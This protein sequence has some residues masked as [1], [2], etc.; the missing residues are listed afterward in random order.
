MRDGSLDPRRMRL[1]LFLLTAVVGLTLAFI[2]FWGY[3]YAVEVAV[4]VALFGG[5]VV[6]LCWAMLS[7]D[8]NRVP[9]SVSE[10]T[11]HAAAL[12]NSM[13]AVPTIGI[14]TALPHETAAVLTVLGDP[15]R[16]H[17]PGT[18]AGRTYWRAE[19]KSANDGQHQVIVAQ[20]DMGNNSAAIRASL[21]LSH[22]PSVESIIMCG[23]AGGIP[24]PGKPEEHVRLGDILVSNQKGVVQ[25]DFVKRTVRKQRVHVVEEVRAAPRPPS[26]TLLDAV[27]ILEADK[28]LERFPWENHLRDGLTKRK[29][30][31]PDETT[32]RLTDPADSSKSIPHPEDVNRRPGQPRVFLAPIASANTL[33][34]DPMKRD[35]LRN[36]F[37]T[38]A[39]EM[40]GSGIADATW[41]HGVGY[42]VIRGICDYCD[43]T[44]NDLWQ[45]YAAMAAAAYV[46][47]LL[48]SIPAPTT[49]SP[50]TGVKSGAASVYPVTA[51]PAEPIPSQ[52]PRFP[53][54][55]SI[56]EPSKSVETCAGDRSKPIA[57]Q[58]DDSKKTILLTL[59]GIKTTG[60]WQKE[61]SPDLQEAGLLA[62]PLDYG[63]FLALQ[64][65]VGRTRRAK[66]EWFLK[67]YQS[68][69][70]RYPHNKVSIIAHSMGTYIVANALA[71]Y[72]QIRFD[73]IIFCGSIVPVDYD[74]TTV[75]ER[76]QANRI[77]H[78][79][80]DQDFWAW[81]VEWFVP[82]TGPSGERGFKDLAGGRVSQQ[83][84]QG[85]RHSDHFYFLN[86]RSR[87]V[88][89]LKG[90]DPAKIPGLQKPPI[91]WKYLAGRQLLFLVLVA[92]VLLLYW[93]FS[94]GSRKPSA[95]VAF[96]HPPVHD[97]IAVA[98]LVGPAGERE[99]WV[100]PTIQKRLQN[101]LDPY[102]GIKLVFLNEG[103]RDAA[104][105]RAASRA[106]HVDILIW[107]SYQA[108]PSH[109]RLDV[110][111]DIWKPH[112]RAPELT[113]APS[114]AGKSGGIAP[115]RFLPEFAPRSTREP[116]IAAIPTLNSFSIQ[117]SLSKDITFLCLFTVGLSRY[118]AGEQRQA[119]ACFDDALTR[120]PDPSAQCYTQV[121]RG[122]CYCELREFPVAR[123][124][125][126]Q[127]VEINPGFAHGYAARAMV[128]MAE[129]NYADSL[130][131]CN[132][133]IELNKT[134]D[135]VALRAS[136]YFLMNDFSQAIADYSESV[137]LGPEE[138]HMYFGLA[139]A[140]WKKAE[141][142]IG[143]D[144]E[145]DLRSTRENLDKAIHLEPNSQWIRTTRG[146]FHASQGNWEAATQDYTVALKNGGD[147]DLLGNRAIARLM[148]GHPGLAIEDLNAFMRR[149]QDNPFAYAYRGEAY[150]NIRQLD[151]AIKDYTHALTLEESAEIRT[152][153]AR[154]YVTAHKL[155]EA[156]DDCNRAIR[157]EPT[158]W[159][160]YYWRARAN[161]AVPNW[162]AAK[163]D[164][165]EALR[166]CPDAKDKE[167]IKVTVAELMP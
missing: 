64:L 81:V 24:S 115:R 30:N 84:L 35:A 119:L 61:I 114:V 145:S 148:S 40:E 93:I 15:P 149:H 146:R 46:R 23:I 124:A 92:T 144:Q 13:S 133:A 10:T 118:F 17:F 75:L 49:Y 147:P 65:L 52:A 36:Q 37:G 102:S 135:Y 62:F 86:Y 68:V 43:A 163:K 159:K 72:S 9:Q 7:S 155:Q 67:E 154:A 34:K 139:A 95:V 25:Y 2:T 113:P 111:F 97:V 22:F 31:R 156:F 39:V 87:W 132:R 134:A 79:Y 126:E 88:P 99:Y 100:T 127:V 109:V 44:K 21:L 160:A 121:Y 117:A 63:N 110:N 122:H 27:R 74:W 26:A 150:Y 71:K 48:E 103:F 112:L 69:K 54:E 158:L 108:S 106:H 165:D 11:R 96:E 3:L 41:N 90:G 19:V 18:G 59:H 129:N 123:K 78:D 8:G 56:E 55:A 167:M 164:F 157:D 70:D 82:D 5:G 85:F 51:L 153:R 151:Q 94:Y 161:C 73:R 143:P 89:F 20:A 29:W 142:E 28:H 91:P 116:V 162:V 83:K 57:D 166:L 60:K 6:V 141:G 16:V 140:F 12:E 105:A 53:G 137:R 33:L 104:A 120:A 76:G 66:I 98:D 38:R 14:I 77:L 125:F 136:A 45:M 128:L 1:I 42:L 4:F 47:A 130:R 152:S 131:D 58:R 50:T 80:G 138:S 101:A 107:G 32:D